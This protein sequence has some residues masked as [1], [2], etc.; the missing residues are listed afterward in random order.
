MLLLQQRSSA[1]IITT[2]AGTGDG[3]F[4]GDGGPAAVA[5][6]YRPLQI[7]IDTAGDI[8][9]I[10][11]FNYR[12]RKIT[13]GIIT[14]VAGNGSFSTSGD[15]GPAT[16]AGLG[17]PFGLA[18]DRAGNLY[19]SEA[20]G[21]CIRKITP[22]GIISSYAGTAGMP[23]FSG[24]GG[25]ATAALLSDPGCMSTD[26]SGNLYFSD[27]QRIRKID[28]TGMITTIAGTGVTGYSGDGGP[29][30]AAT[31]SGA[32][33]AIVDGLG[34]V[35]VADA[36]NFVV[37]K[38]NA[39]GII[40]T[41]AG[42]GGSSFS[43][44]GGPATA[45][46]IGAINGLGCDFA[47][48]L[49]IGTSYYDSSFAHNA[50]LLQVDLAG[51]IHTISGAGPMGYTGDGGPATAA[52]LHG[53]LFASRNGNGDIFFSDAGD[54]V[55]RRISAMPYF[56]GPLNSI[57][58][59]CDTTYNIDT[60]LAVNDS[61]S[62]NPM[63]WSL[64]S[65][66]HHGSASISYSTTSTGYT[67][68]PSGLSYTPASGYTGADTLQARI[69]DSLVSDTITLYLHVIDCDAAVTSVTSSDELNIYPD[70]SV[71]SFTVNWHTS[72]GQQATMV[73]SNMEGI[74][75]EKTIINANTP[76][77]VTLNTPPGLYLVQLNTD[78]RVHNRKLVIE[79]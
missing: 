39:A 47:G 17:S 40:T 35:Y 21:A 67:V 66:P 58:T 71:G 23:G 55:I 60:L 16:A 75:V 38:I 56:A 2:I 44:D 62:G 57:D 7:A 72:G 5:E 20:G 34:N 73:I 15:G 18:V 53:N 13:H 61:F 36:G 52:E 79:Q 28:A 77:P 8:Y 64:V 6:L 27:N 63:S 3:G 1:Q 22:S 41:C 29:A 30:T 51:Y 59:L 54:N 49:Y 78:N 33:A 11:A 26:T 25:P 50:K 69:T 48:N 4:S 32:G 31:F 19:L 45:A 76:L 46:A 9:F 12:I 70:P 10:D 68:I 14:T 65:G 74:V 43:G 37:R 42:T 24:D